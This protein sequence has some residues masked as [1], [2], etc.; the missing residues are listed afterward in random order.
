MF[1]GVQLGNV[2]TKIISTN[3]STPI[4][5][6][7]SN[8]CIYTTQPHLPKDLLLLMINIVITVVII[9]FI[10]IIFS[11]DGCC[12]LDILPPQQIKTSDLRCSGFGCLFHNILAIPGRHSFC[13]ISNVG[14]NS[15]F[16]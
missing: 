16:L 14:S 10:I 3:I 13:N 12:F 7:Y 15:N 5:L 6:T 1:K 2:N 8:I 4:S 11:Q 9:I